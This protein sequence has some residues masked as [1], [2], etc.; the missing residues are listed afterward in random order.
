MESRLG[1]QSIRRSESLPEC[2]Y[3]KD[4]KESTRQSQIIQTFSLTHQY[5]SKIN[6][7]SDSCLN[8][9]FCLVLSEAKAIL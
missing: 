3:G 5:F 2:I 1:S 8:G 4:E 6:H 7:F 9:C